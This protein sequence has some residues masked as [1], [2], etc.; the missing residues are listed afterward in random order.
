MSTKSFVAV[1]ALALAGLV[2]GCSTAN[3]SPDRIEYQS[4]PAPRTLEI[5][6]DLTQLPRD[7]RFTVPD[8]AGATT[9]VTASAAAA[10]ASRGQPR[11][12]TVLAV[13][14]IV[15]NARIEREGT[16]RWLAVDVP[17]EQAYNV[18]REFLPTIGLQ[19][20][21][22][23]AKTGIVE[24]AWAENRANLPQ[25]MIRGL[26]GRFLGQVYSTGEMDK[27]RFRVERTA[28]NTSEVFVSHR[29][30]VE[31]FTSQAQDSTKWQ[32]RPP[33]PELEVELLQ[34]LAQRFAPLPAQATAAGAG[35]AAVGG[36]PIATVPDI[37]RLLPADASNP[38][39]VSINEPFDRAW[40]RVGLALDRGGFTV[41][42]RDRA[43][44][45]Y[46]VRYLDPEIEQKQRDNQGFLSR[47]FGRDAKVEAQQFRV[48]VA[49]VGERTVVTV[50]DRE[51]K[52]DSSPTSGKILAQIND[53]LR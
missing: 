31:V 52:P 46:F 45:L 32:P 21:R 9:S 6:P 36:V 2:A 7:D 24:T 51:G 44:G 8:R 16:Q 30:M 41:E 48:L 29:G 40:R 5:P 37:A 4:A 25:S 11:G 33:D 17:P 50:Q 3:L 35:A 34:R 1:A 27:F 53:Q 13:A 14:P 10:A 19:I 20:E 15:P 18:V 28:A 42:D 26:L 39:R 49:A 38:A 23:D 22:E 47:I 43:R 12:G